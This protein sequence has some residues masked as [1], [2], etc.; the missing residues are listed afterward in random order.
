MLVKGATASDFDIS[1]QQVTNDKALIDFV[2]EG[3]FSREIGC[4]RHKIKQSR[5]NCVFRIKFASWLKLII[6]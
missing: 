2:K 1:S 5:N 6:E 4:Y 3:G